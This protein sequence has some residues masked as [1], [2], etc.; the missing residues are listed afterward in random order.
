MTER[1]PSSLDGGEEGGAQTRCEFDAASLLPR[2]ELTIPGE[3]GSVTPAVDRIMAVISQMKC[4]EGK[5]FEIRTALQEALANAVIH[6]CGEDS[7]KQVQVCVGCD[8]TRGMII[9]VRDPGEGFDPTELPSPLVGENLFFSHGRGVYLINQLMDEVRYQ[10]GG[11]EI[12]M[13]KS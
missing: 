7:E 8:E 12:W 3:V 2:M 11:T 10:K 9:V 4:G 1:D 5:E 13:R 6:G